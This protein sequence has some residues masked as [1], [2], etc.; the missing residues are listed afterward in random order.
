MGFCKKC[1]FRWLGV[2]AAHCT[3]CHRTF[4]SANAFDLHRR[5]FRCLDPMDLGMIM[6][7][8]GF[9]TKPMSEDAVSMVR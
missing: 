8:R 9:W 1:N 6:N 3:G 4:K 2:S 7:D 5:D